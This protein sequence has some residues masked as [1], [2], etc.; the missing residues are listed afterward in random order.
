[1]SGPFID[2]VGIIVEDLHASLGLFERLFGMRPDTV[3]EMPD[4]GLKIAHLRAQNVG[5][6]LIQYTRKGCFGEKVMGARKGLNHLSFHVEDIDS[7]LKD[8]QEKGIH[9]MEGFPMQGSQGP[10]AFF[11]PETTGEILL[12][13]CHHPGEGEKG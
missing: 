5:I 13:L 2:H 8:W 6:E 3:K 12:E 7:S 4:A 9:V 1:M 10:V 11:E